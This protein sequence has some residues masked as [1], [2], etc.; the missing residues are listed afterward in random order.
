MPE[1]TIAEKLVKLRYTHNLERDEL[2]KI[3]NFHHD[4][5]DAWERHNIM[6]KPE[7]ILIL[8]EY[9]HVPLKYFHEYYIIYFDNPGEKI[10]KWKDN[11][12]LTYREASKLL[13]I[14]HSGFGRLLSGKVHLSYELYLKLKKLGTL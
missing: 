13:G 6:P 3:L 10:K 7:N 9:F 4:T 8:C 1:N 2:A 11:K 14:T 5:L 12:G